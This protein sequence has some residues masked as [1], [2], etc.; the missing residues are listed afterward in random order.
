MTLKEFLKS[1]SSLLEWYPARIYSIKN[2]SVIGSVINS[3]ELIPE[4][5][6]EYKYIS[7][8][9]EENTRIKGSK[10]IVITVE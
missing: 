5:V 8:K 10:V 7:M 2:H 6:Y 4:N 9:I 1:I 3:K